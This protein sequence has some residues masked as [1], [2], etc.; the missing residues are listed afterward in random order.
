MTLGFSAC[1]TVRYITGERKKK[2]EIGGK[3]LA[4]QNYTPPNLLKARSMFHHFHFVPVKI[5]AR[6]NKENGV[7]MQI[8]IGIFFPFHFISFFSFQHH[9]APVK[10]L[11]PNAIVIITILATLS[12][13]SSSS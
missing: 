11:K 13:C 1:R 2:R 8:I 7:N 4:I 5:S 12:C 9:A 6:E 10:R 3:L